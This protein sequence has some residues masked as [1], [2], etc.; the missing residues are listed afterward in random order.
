MMWSGVGVAKP[1]HLFLWRSALAMADREYD[2]PVEPLKTAV[3]DSKPRDKFKVP[4][5]A[6]SA[7]TGRAT[8]AATIAAIAPFLKLAPRLNNMAI[9]LALQL[10]IKT[11]NLPI[12]API[13]L[14]L[15]E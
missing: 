12:A 2:P 5:L 4:K 15:E 8:M 13:I 3:G 10:K 6:V 9:L 11:L 7:K 1:K 14:T